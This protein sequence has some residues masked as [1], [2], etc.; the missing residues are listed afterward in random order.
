MSRATAQPIR[1][2]Q[3]LSR[4]VPG[5]R[6]RTLGNDQPQLQDSNTGDMIDFHGPCDEK[7]DEYRRP[8]KNG[9][10]VD[11]T[12]TAKELRPDR[13]G[14]AARRSQRPALPGGDDEISQLL[15]LPNIV[16]H[17]ELRKKN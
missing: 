17:C 12:L 13:R 9:P 15:I 4:E 16:A 10:A 5:I 14:G 2:N 11:V 3:L 7:S 1:R 6:Q 8:G